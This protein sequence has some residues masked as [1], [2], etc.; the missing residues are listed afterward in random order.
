[1]KSIFT[2][3][4]LLPILTYTQNVKQGD[5]EGVFG[6]DDLNKIPG[7][8]DYTNLKYWIAHPEVEDMAD[9]TPGKGQFRNGQSEAQVDVFFVYPTIYTGEQNASFPWFADVDD[10]ELNEK[11]ANSTIKYQATVFNR[12]AK[13]YSPLYRQAHVAVFRSDSSLRMP[14]LDL[15]YLDVKNAFE[16][17][18]KNWNNDRPIIIAAHSQGTLHA[19]RLLKEFFEGKPLMQKLVA[20]YIVGMPVQK[21]HFTELPICESPDQNTC[22]MTWN[23]YLAGYYP[24]YHK[25]WYMNAASVNPLTWATNETWASRN[26]NSGGVLKNYKKVLPRLTDAQ[27]HDGMLWIHKPRFFGNFLL[28]WKRFHNVDYNLFYSNIRENVA[29]RVEKYL[30]NASVVNN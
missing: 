6:M 14:S 13:I 2:F 27:N 5:Y 20:A 17:Y 26:E 24:P 30:E 3:L 25:T 18:L 23:T 4:L 15:A 22:W 1:M 19:A 12:S 8:P 9:V 28:N 16:Y 7:A 29:T 11:I 21:N 10:A